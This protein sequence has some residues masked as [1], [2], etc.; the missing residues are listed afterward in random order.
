MQHLIAIVD[1]SYAGVNI[2]SGNPFDASDE[3]ARIL[4]TIGKAMDA[5]DAPVAAVQ[6]APAQVETR[7]VKADEG[8]GLF[9]SKTDEGQPKR[10][11][12][13][14]RDMRAET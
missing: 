10:K 5:P 7:A 9:D 2:L 3:D 1:L 11:R 8:D 13:N 12:Y 4:R 14:R 6:A